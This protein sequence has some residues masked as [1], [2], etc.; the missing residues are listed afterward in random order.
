VVAAV[1]VAVEPGVG[2]PDVVRDQPLAG[3][4]FLLLLVCGTFLAYLALSALPRLMVLV[5]GTGGVSP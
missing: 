1:A 4:P 2:L 5:R 3:V